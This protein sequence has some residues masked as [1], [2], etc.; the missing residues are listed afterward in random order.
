MYFLALSLTP[1]Y[2]SHLHPL[3]LAA[4]YAFNDVFS[5]CLKHNLSRL[6]HGDV[7]QFILGQIFC[8]LST[9]FELFSTEDYVAWFQGRLGLFLSS[10]NAQNLGFLPSDMTCNS[11]AAM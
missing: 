11:L 5:F 3:I 2:Q 4:I 1:F 7:R 9:V 10:L 6:P 8:H